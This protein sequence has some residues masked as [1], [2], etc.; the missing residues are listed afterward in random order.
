MA[1]VGDEPALLEQRLLQAVQQR[2]HRLRQL[3]HLVP[4]ARHLQLGVAVPDRERLGLPPQALDR[5]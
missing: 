5:P 1:G 3:G 4:G 2:V